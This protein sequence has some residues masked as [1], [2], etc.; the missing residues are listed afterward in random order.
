M[1]YYIGI[2]PRYLQDVHSLLSTQE[3]FL[4]PTPSWN[5]LHFVS[6]L[7]LHMQSHPGVFWLIA[8]AMITFLLWTNQCMP[9]ITIT[10][11]IVS[12]QDKN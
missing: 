4:I 12:T 8:I 5:T 3:L 7:N 11:K 1:D 9:E 6:I 2:S 10:A